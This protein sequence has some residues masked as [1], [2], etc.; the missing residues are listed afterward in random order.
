[1]S[2]ERWTNSK[3]LESGQ[4]SP[5]LD[6]GE[7]SKWTEL[8]RRSQDLVINTKLYGQKSLLVYSKRNLVST[9]TTLMKSCEFLLHRNSKLEKMNIGFTR[10]EPSPLGIGKGHVTLFQHCPKFYSWILVQCLSTSHL[11]IN[12]GIRHK[13]L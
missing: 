12:T 8:S 7:H 5:V 2:P 10:M 1:M 6:R 9:Q 13:G 11:F 3:Q 4:K